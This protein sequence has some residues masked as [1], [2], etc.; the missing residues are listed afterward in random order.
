[1]VLALRVPTLTVAALAQWRERW[2]HVTCL[3]GG[4][5]DGDGQLAAWP[6]Q[7]MAATGGGE[8]V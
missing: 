8:R 7:A 6:A 4:A 3:I 2:Q 5:T 1:M